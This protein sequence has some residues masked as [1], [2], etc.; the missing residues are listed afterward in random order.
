MKLVS[1]Y[2]RITWG[3]EIAQSYSSGLRAGSGVQVPAGIG[4]YSLHHRVQ[5]GSGPHPA[6][7]SMGT[8]GSYPGDKAT[9]TW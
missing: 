1:S 7:Y 4:N 3:A 5:T 6:F 9:E 8:G 2:T